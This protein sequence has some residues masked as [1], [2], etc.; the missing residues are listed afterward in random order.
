M[1]S[2]STL[3]MSWCPSIRSRRGYECDAN[4]DR[5]VRPYP[6]RLGYRD[7]RRLL[8]GS[9]FVPWLELHFP[10][11]VFIVSVH[12]LDRHVPAFTRQRGRKVARTAIHTSG[13]SA[14]MP[15]RPP[16]PQTKRQADKGE[17]PQGTGGTPRLP[18]RIGSA[19]VDLS[20]C[21]SLRCG[22]SL[23]TALDRVQEHAEDE[24]QQ[25]KVQ[26]HL[27]GHYQ[28][29]ALTSGCDVAESDRGENRHR[30]VH[31]IGARQRLGEG[32]LIRGSQ[33]QILPGARPSS[34][35][36]LDRRRGHALRPTALSLHVDRGSATKV[37]GSPGACWR[38]CPNLALGRDGGCRGEVGSSDEIRPYDRPVLGDAGLRLARLHALRARDPS[39]C[40]FSGASVSRTTARSQRCSGRRAGPA[41]KTSR[42]RCGRTRRSAVRPR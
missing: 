24:T 18:Q 29:G 33:V 12:L 19:A 42:C 15:T 28:T 20:P 25:Q 35:S 31:G 36:D 23:V 27:D 22:L 38:L 32:L 17:T 40:S 14:T 39:S 1:S 8:F 5:A 13:R 4:R 6:H 3:S 16:R 10:A 7:Q 41:P 11:W 2:I 9:G 37:V 34:P 30:D 26:Q 21:C